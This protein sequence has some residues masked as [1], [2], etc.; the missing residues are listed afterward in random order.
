MHN[1]KISERPLYG[2][3]APTSGWAIFFLLADINGSFLSSLASIGV[4]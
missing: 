2:R 4:T 3:L 1:T